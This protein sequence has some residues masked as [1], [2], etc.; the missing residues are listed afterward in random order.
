MKTSRFGL[1]ENTYVRE[2]ELREDGVEQSSSETT[3]GVNNN[4]STPILRFRQADMS[5][6]EGKM[7]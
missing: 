1:L 4:N 6:H 3:A 5:S 2:L 7:Y